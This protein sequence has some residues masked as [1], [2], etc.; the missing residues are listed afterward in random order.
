MSLF[1]SDA[2]ADAAA[3]ELVDIL[4]LSMVAGVG[5]KMR[6]T[7]LQRF[8][9]PAAVLAAAPSELRS[10]SGVGP[11]LMERITAA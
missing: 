10:V 3:G 8:G 4:R 5:P 7:L 11:K 9:T 1:E 2:P 6:H